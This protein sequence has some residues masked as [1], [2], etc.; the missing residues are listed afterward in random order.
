[1]QTYSEPCDCCEGFGRVLSKETMGAKID[2]WFI[3]ASA[4]KKYSSFHLVVN[5]ALADALVGE[6]SSAGNRLRRIMKQKRVK[7]NLVRDTSI[8]LQEFR[9]FEAGENREIT[10]DYH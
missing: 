5:P 8:S 3:R 10:S 9:V 6:N 2:R 4:D 1:M 7:V